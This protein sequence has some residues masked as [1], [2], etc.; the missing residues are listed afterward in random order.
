MPKYTINGVT[1]NSA[2]ELSDADLEELS[3]GASTAPA[4]PAA[5]AAPQRSIPQELARQVGLTGRA[6]YEAFTSPATMLLEAVR[7]GYNLGA[8]ALGSQS[9]MDSPA[10]AQSRRLTAMGVPEPENATERAVQAGTQAMASTAGMAKLAPQ[11]PALAADLVRQVPVAGVS[12]LVAQPTAEVV[13]EVT[14]SDTAATIAGILAGTVTAASSGKAIDYKFRPRETIAQVKE[15]AAQSYQ[16][17]DDA[18]ITLKPDSVQKMFKSIG[19][20]LDDAR[21]VPGTDSAREVTARLNEMARVLG[22]SPVLPFS[23]VDK[24]RAM[25]NDLKGSKDPDVRRLGSVA[26]T[27]VDDYISENQFNSILDT[28]VISQAEC[29]TCELLKN[30]LKDKIAVFHKLIESCSNGMKVDDSFK[31]FLTILT[32]EIERPIISQLKQLTGSY[33]SYFFHI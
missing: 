15:R 18:G 12:G 3:G 8:E 21:M 6:A 30:L 16:A 31:T 2:T 5:Q 17:V 14:G 20:A 32:A 27:K 4:A 10:A 33:F 28:E 23:S 9:R 19:T 29:K 25:L 24:M 13:K 11:V 26:V 22:D 7:G 1:Y